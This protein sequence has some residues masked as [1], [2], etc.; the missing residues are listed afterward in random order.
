MKEY[1]LNSNLW[2]INNRINYFLNDVLNMVENEN[3]KQSLKILSKE[4]NTM[5]W[6]NKFWI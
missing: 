5:E 1:L 6:I 2:F 4:L 3:K